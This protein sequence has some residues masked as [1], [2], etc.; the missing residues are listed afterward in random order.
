MQFEVTVVIQLVVGA[1]YLGG[2]FMQIFFIQ[3][4]VNKLEARVGVVDA[5]LE[6]GEVRMTRMETVCEMR[7]GSES[8]S[9]AG[10]GRARE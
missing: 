10:R 1:A 4:L 6:A 9:V 3:R 2:V 5:R 8:L 7:H